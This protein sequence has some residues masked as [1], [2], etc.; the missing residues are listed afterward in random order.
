[1]ALGLVLLI[2]RRQTALAVFLVFRY[3]ILPLAAGCRGVHRGTGSSG[4]TGASGSVGGH[5]RAEG[6]Q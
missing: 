4:L 6:P 1:M 5:G 3:V 2:P